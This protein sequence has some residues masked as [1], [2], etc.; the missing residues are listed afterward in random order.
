MRLSTSAGP[1]ARNSLAFA[2]QGRADHRR[3][4]GPAGA[5]RS[6]SAD[7]T[8]RRASG[9]PRAGN[10]ASAAD[11]RRPKMPSARPRSYPISRSRSCNS[12]TSSPNCGSGCA[13]ASTRDPRRHRA[14]SRARQVSSFTSP[15]TVSPRSCWKARTARSDARVEHRV[16]RHW[17]GIGQQAQFGQ[18][19]SDLD[20]RVAAVPTPNHLHGLCPPLLGRTPQMWRSLLRAGLTSVATGVLVL[21]GRGAAESW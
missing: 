21:P 20:D 10:F 7:R 9:R 19:R 12:R 5:A 14:A 11:V 13:W 2:Q 16:G 3:P 15:V 18:D 4:C 1:A 6:S 17:R 8:R